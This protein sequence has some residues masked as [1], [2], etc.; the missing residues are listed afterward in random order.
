MF[1]KRRTAK[2]KDEPS[3]F[4]GGPA[5]F[6]GPG[7]AKGEEKPKRKGPFRFNLMLYNRR[8]PDA[9]A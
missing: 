8:K 4:G 9:D 5:G 7:G 2:P 3:L 1:I 6:F